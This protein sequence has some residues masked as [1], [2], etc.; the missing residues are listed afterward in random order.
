[1]VA[2]LNDAIKTSSFTDTFHHSKST[3]EGH[4]ITSVSSFSYTDPIDKSVST[5]QGYIVSFDEDESRVVFRLSGTGSAGATVRMYVEQ[6]V[7]PDVGEK[8]LSRSTAAGLKGLIEVA[9][10]IAKLKEFLGRD[11]PTVITVRP[12]S[13][14]ST[15][16][17]THEVVL[18]NTP[19]RKGTGMA[20]GYLICT[21]MVQW[22]LIFDLWPGG[23]SR[24]GG[25]Q[26]CV[27][28]PTNHRCAVG[29]MYI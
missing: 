11:E 25:E 13:F 8:E 4:S 23:E 27:S 22:S 14:D 7:W 16:S 10:E 17:P 19:Y 26:A 5:N 18:V 3:G 21:M 28:Y 24:K 9:L 20:S 29:W 1:M 15:E 12:L 6:Y 2:H